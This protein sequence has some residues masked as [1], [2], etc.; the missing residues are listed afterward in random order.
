MSWINA[1]S[2]GWFKTYGIRLASGRDFDARDRAGAALVA[3]VNRAFAR[4][5]LKEGDP[6]GQQFSDEGPG[7]TGDTFDVIG[8][9]EDSIYRSLRSAM[10]PTMFLAQ[11]PSGRRPGSTRRSGFDRPARRPRL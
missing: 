10:E 4:R 11:R 1:V 6:V 8:L 7:G 9:V 3:V 5:F 2:P